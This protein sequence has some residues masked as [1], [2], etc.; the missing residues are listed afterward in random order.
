VN[1]VLVYVSVTGSLKLYIFHQFMF[2]PWR[3]TYIQKIGKVN[4]YHISSFEKS[5]KIFL[6]FQNH[7]FSTSIEMVDYVSNTLR[8][9]V[10]DN[11]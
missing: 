7:I 11:W 8:Q 6:W 10:F 3:T 5:E 9:V 1:L 2:K 4:V